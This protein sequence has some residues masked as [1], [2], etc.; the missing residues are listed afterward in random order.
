MSF[1]M[2]DIVEDVRIGWKHGFQD[3]QGRETNGTKEA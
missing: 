2:R 3:I 1:S